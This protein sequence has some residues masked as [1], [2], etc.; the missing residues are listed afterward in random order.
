MPYDIYDLCDQVRQI[1]YDIHIFH[2]HGYLE[3]VYENALAHWLR[4][5]ELRVEQQ[6]P[7]MVRDIDGTPIGEFY[8]DLL[9]EGVLIIELKTVRSLA[10]EH[11]AQILSYL[12]STRLQHGMLI[13][14]GSVKFE[15][16]KFIWTD[17][18]NQPERT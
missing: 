14:F 13:N 9:I 11:E 18:R 3:K 6:C 12:K 7:I 17:K 10:S 5:T 4:N 8:A 2:G 1:A 16:R 15:I